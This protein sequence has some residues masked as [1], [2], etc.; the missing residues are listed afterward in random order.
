MTHWKCVTHAWRWNFWMG[1][2]EPHVMGH[3]EPGSRCPIKIIT[4]Q[5]HYLNVYICHFVLPNNTGIATTGWHDI[6]CFVF[7]WYHIGS[8][9]VRNRKPKTTKGVYD[10]V[11]MERA[12][13]E[14]IHNNMLISSQNMIV[15]RPRPSLILNCSYSWK[16]T[17]RIP[18]LLVLIYIVPS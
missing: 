7:A 17:K 10:S 3:L 15:S 18:C 4:V 14:V 5:Y 6:Y 12:L 8:V 16:F 2:V 1:Q 9:M 11:A 13:Q